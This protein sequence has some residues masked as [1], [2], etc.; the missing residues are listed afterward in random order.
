MTQTSSAILFAAAAAGRKA[1]LAFLEQGLVECE[2]N[3]TDTLALLLKYSFGWFADGKPTTRPLAALDYVYRTP[4]SYAVEHGSEAGT[5][6]FGAA[7]SLGTGPCPEEHKRASI[8][9]NRH[10]I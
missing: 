6:Q 8:R 10:Q 4:L 1:V 3:P 9:A 7:Q 2:N 5:G